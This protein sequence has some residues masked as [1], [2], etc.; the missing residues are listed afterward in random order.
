MTAVTGNTGHHLIVA[1]GTAAGRGHPA[2]Y[3]PESWL[4]ART[5]GRSINQ[6]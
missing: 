1:G 6:H 3:V 2:D 4:A 5:G